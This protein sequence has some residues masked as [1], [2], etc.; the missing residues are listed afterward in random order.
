MG[1]SDRAPF[2]GNLV[3]DDFMIRYMAAL[4]A[5]P[6]DDVEHARVELYIAISKRFVEDLA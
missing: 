6:S 3:D 2:Q 1:R 4:K 5:V